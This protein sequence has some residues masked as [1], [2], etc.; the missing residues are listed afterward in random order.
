M[1]NTYQ[2]METVYT[3]VLIIVDVDGCC[4]ICSSNALSICPVDVLL[5]DADAL[6]FLEGTAG[7]LIASAR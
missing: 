2:R 1:C 6:L 4:C 3:C 7:G 5:G